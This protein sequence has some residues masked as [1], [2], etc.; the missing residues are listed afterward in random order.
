MACVQYL[1]NIVDKN[2]ILNSDCVSYAKSIGDLYEKVT[3][4]SRLENYR[5]LHYGNIG[6]QVFKVGIQNQIN[7]TRKVNDIHIKDCQLL[8]NSCQEMPKFH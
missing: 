7:F 1:N 2:K 4:K 3:Q 8:T 5:G 6:C